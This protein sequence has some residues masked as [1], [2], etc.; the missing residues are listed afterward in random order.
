KAYVLEADAA[1]VGAGRAP[2]EPLVLHVNVGDCVLVDLANRTAGPVSLHADQLAFDPADSA[3]VAAGR[4]PRQA[5]DP[6][7]RRRYRF[8]ASPEVGP[9]AGLLRDW[10]GVV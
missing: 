3:G 4:E 7:K 2:P 10:G 8:Y 5:V 1:A 9:T 6:G